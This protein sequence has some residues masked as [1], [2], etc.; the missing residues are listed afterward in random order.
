M[1]YRF[2]I[3]LT[4]FFAL[5]CVS[6]VTTEGVKTALTPA[7]GIA[8]EAVCAADDCTEYWQRAQLWL[9]KH[10]NMKIQTSTDVLLQ[11]YNPPSSAG[12]TYGFTIT[13]E[14]LAEGQYKI[15]MEANCSGMMCS[16]KVEE[17]YK[18]FY[19]YVKTGED[20]LLGVEDGGLISIK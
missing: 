1:R 15:V 19:Y 18:A 11:T 20:L 8:F 3:L 14:P 9:A 10:S 2:L 7:E 6:G 13:K 4:L 12:S 5:G 17:V 16:P